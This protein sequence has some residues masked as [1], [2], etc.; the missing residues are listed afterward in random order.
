MTGLSNDCIMHSYSSKR[1][2][3]LG[4]KSVTD[5]FWKTTDHINRS[6]LTKQ[7]AAEPISRLL[8][9]CSSAWRSDR[10]DAIIDK[11][12]ARRP[13]MQWVTIWRM[14]ST[15]RQDVYNTAKLWKL[16]TRRAQRKR[17]RR[18]GLITVMTRSI[19][20]IDHKAVLADALG[21]WLTHVASPQTRLT[22]EHG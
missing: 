16:M 8:L 14:Q 18:H 12:K 17:C 7:S 3:R 22:F 4:V 21:V 10:K 15:A 13:A 1:Y 11:G 5:M 20:F 9:K 6:I 2:M 19:E